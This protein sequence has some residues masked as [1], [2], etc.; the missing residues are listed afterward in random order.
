MMAGWALYNLCCH[1]MGVLECG[2]H[3]LPGLKGSPDEPLLTAEAG[4]APSPEG[5][6]WVGGL[7]LSFSGPQFPIP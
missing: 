2:V 3:C 5:N 1:L 4:V 6:D 7:P